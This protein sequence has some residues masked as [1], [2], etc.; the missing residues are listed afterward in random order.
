MGFA[1]DLFSLSMKK[2]NRTK[3]KKQNERKKVY[4]EQNQMI[5]QDTDKGRRKFAFIFIFESKIKTKASFSSY[6]IKSVV[7]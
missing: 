5:N 6:R 4:C 7:S 2:Q 3:N 1:I